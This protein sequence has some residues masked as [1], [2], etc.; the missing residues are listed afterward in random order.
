MRVGIFGGTFDP[1]H[2]GHLIM[3]DQAREGAELDE[4]WFVPAQVPPHKLQGPVALPE[5]RIAM[6]EKAIDDH[7][8]FRVS[9]LEMERKGPSYTVDTVTTLTTTY[10]KDQFFLIMGGDMVMN[11]P[12]WH[13]VEEIMEQVGVV[14]LGRPDTQLDWRALPQMIRDRLI[15]I[16]QGVKIDL[17]ST[18]IREQ[19]AQGGS[20]RYLV[21]EC[22]RLFIKENQIYEPQPVD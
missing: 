21:P 18:Y 7:P 11:L 22:V 15:L 5:Q 4:V 2:I 8:H 1:I 6:V 16:D 17:S 9:G 20:I 10:P 19:M 3:A 12:Q 14:G 13:R